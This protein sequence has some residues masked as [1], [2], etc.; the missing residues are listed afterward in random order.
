MEQAVQK[1]NVI[2]NKIQSLIEQ[3][4]QLNQH[5]KSNQQELTDVKKE[6]VNLQQ[7]NQSLLEQINVIK[8]AKGVGLNGDESVKIKEQIKTYIGEIDEILANIGK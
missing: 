7:Q 6:I 8:L 5:L 3:N 1:W 2:M 4:Q